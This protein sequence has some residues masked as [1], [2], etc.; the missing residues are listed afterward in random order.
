MVVT[1]NSTKI[2]V[3]DV[4]IA[5]ED[6]TTPTHW[7][8]ARII[9][10]HPGKDGIVRVV[11]IRASS[12]REYTRPVVKIVYVKVFGRRY[13]LELTLMEL[14]YGTGRLFHSVLQCFCFVQLELQLIKCVEVNIMMSCCQV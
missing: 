3:G 9:K 1:L 14:L 8:L 2:S 7:P 10:T 13:M 12:G 5:R 11:T 6:N 4:V